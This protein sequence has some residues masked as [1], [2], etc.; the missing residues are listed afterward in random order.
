MAIGIGPD[1]KEAIQEVG[2]GYTI[3]DIGVS[4]EVLKSESN[5]QVTKPFIR[6]FFLEAM[7]AYDTSGE[8]GNIL[9]FER[10]QNRYVVMNITDDIF[11]NEVFRKN[12]VL[13]KCNINDGVLMRPSGED[14]IRDTY[15]TQT[16]WS[17]ITGEISALMTQ[18]LFGNDPDTDE[19]LGR[20]GIERH[21]LYIPSSIGIQELDRFE[22]VSGEYYV[23]SEVI[24]RRYQSV[25]VVRLEED[26]R[27]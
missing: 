1:I 14:N 20:I 19:E 9:E 16:H 11:E 15:H 7:M 17:H 10:N 2:T 6:E 8:V 12:A 27:E 26:Q 5:A 3:V 25:D 24:K 21:E 4:G 22:A 18:P 13:Y 23:V